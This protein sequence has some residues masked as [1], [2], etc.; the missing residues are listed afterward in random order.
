MDDDTETAD[1]Q[2]TIGDTDLLSIAASFAYAE[3]AE[4]EESHGLYGS[5]GADTLTPED[6][7]AL[8]TEAMDQLLGNVSEIRAGVGNDEIDLT[9]IVDELSPADGTIGIYGGEGDDLITA[10]TYNYPVTLSGGEGDDTLSG[11][12]TDI[13]GG[14]GDDLIT[15]TPFSPEEEPSLQQVDGGAG[16]DTIMAPLGFGTFNGNSGNDVIE[17][18]GGTLLGGSGTDQITYIRSTEENGSPPHGAEISGGGGDDTITVSLNLEP[19]NGYRSGEYY[20]RS[21]QDYDI[22]IE[23]G[24]GSDLIV[25][26]A[27][28]NFVEGGN[29]PTLLATLTDFDP[30]EDML[31]V[32]L[33]A[34]QDTEGMLAAIMDYHGNGPGAPLGGTTSNH[35]LLDVSTET[36]ADGSYTDYIITTSGTTTAGGTVIQDFAIRIMGEAGSLS[37]SYFNFRDAPSAQSIT[38]E[39][40]T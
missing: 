36:A 33:V 12:S 22:E 38:F 34:N 19:D 39:I 10:E 5:D 32:D 6:F 8:E 20:V 14:P 3:T 11:A 35:Q 27:A 18:G 9:G 24:T 2:D 7:D 29:E 1:P 31:L 23:S 26:D 25:I 21:T 15:S 13:S 30:T 17:T 28:L 37:T 40:G 4:S 16:N